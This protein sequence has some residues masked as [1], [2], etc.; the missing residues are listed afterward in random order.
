[1]LESYLPGQGVI[2]SGHVD[3]EILH[4]AIAR[5]DVVTVKKLHERFNMVF[6][7]KAGQYAAEHGQL[8]T[9]KYM[10]VRGLFMDESTCYY[11]IKGDQLAV[12]QFLLTE[13]KC[14]MSELMFSYAAYMGRMGIAE[15]LYDLEC[16]WDD[17]V[18]YHAARG[19][20]VHMLRFL[21]ERKCPWNMSAVVTAF[22]QSQESERH[23]EAFQYL[24]SQLMGHSQNTQEE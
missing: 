23:R 14:V 18:T 17:D 4:N 12:L 5:G 10:Y 15:Y 8:E 7:R 6:D 1:M 16:P 21:L 13:G 22:E 24:Q 19:G 11:A 2:S 3:Q 20:H 9:L